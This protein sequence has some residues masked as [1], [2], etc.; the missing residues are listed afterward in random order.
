MTMNVMVC[1]Q[2]AMGAGFVSAGAMGAP[3]GGTGTS[4]VDCGSMDMDIVLEAK[5]RCPSSYNEGFGFL[6]ERVRD[7]VVIISGVR[8][9]I[10]KFQG[11]LIIT[12]SSITLSFRN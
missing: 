1:H 6:K 4:G 9:P 7:E 8:P 5:G 10:G 2:G 3:A 12:T 11:A